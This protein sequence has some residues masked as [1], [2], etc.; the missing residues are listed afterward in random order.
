MRHRWL[1]TVGVLAVALM[2]LAACGSDKK[3]TSGAAS[4]GASQSS[5]GGAPSGKP[6]VIAAVIPQSGAA[7]ASFTSA[8]VTAKAGAD[9]LNQ[10]GGIAGRPVQLDL[11]D[12]AG[13]PAQ[14]ISALTAYLDS[15]TP[16]MVIAGPVSSLVQPVLPI[17]MPRKVFSMGSTVA[18]E[19]NDPSKYPYYFPAVPTTTQ[20]EEAL[21]GYLKGKSYKKAA[22]LGP[23]NASGQSALA[24][25]KAAA[26]T[27][28][29]QE[30]DALMDPTSVDATAQLSQLRSASP[31]V[32]VMDG[33]GAFAGVFLKSKARLSWDIPTVADETFAANNLG[34]QATVDDLK[35]VTL[36]FFSFSIKGDPDADR[37]VAK[38]L[39]NA[40]TTAGATGTAFWANAVNWNIFPLAK[41]A[42]DKAGPDADGTALTKALESYQDL[43]ANIKDLFFGAPK[44]GY[45]TTNHAPLWQTSDFKFVNAGPLENTLLVPGS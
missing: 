1:K 41:L 35:N 23:D 26:Q 9:Y 17:L 36:Q 12:S 15:H 31:D 33:F 30:T 24:A 4:G 22:F 16:Q 32:L 28:G 18:Q 43:P 34:Q 19:L 7:A 13:T 8:V 29:L 14:A 20:V 42:G 40:L 39:L 3:T 10:H 25:F 11:I 5:S 37:P 21:A 38:F 2:V 44:L 6:W 45:S 27:A